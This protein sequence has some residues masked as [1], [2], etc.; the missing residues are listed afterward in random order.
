[1]GNNRQNSGG[2]SKSAAAPVDQYRRSIGKHQ[3]K[4]LSDSNV[5]KKI[6]QRNK[7]QGT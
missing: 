4:L 7:D 2:T 5:R 1:M 6:N 3:E